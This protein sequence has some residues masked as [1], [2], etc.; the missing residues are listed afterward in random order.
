MAF[1]MGLLLCVLPL[2]L[3]AE[4][5][6]GTQARFV[7]VKAKRSL[8]LP[9]GGHLPLLP[10]A[11]TRARRSGYFGLPINSI[12]LI[13]N[14]IL[15]SSRANGALFNYKARIQNQK[16]KPPPGE[17]SN[18][19]TEGKTHT[20]YTVTCFLASQNS[21]DHANSRRRWRGR[22]GSTALRGLRK[23]E[24]TRWRRTAGQRD[25]EPPWFSRYR[26]SHRIS[27]NTIVQSTW[28]VTS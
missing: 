24:I 8:L 9:K 27:T 26:E 18:N 22:S 15:R 16:K 25:A 17:C 3:F 7:W 13:E 21:I 20:C 2:L 28:R 23:P 11:L 10:L 1:V 4:M 6:M 19:V 14:I 5:L 12:R